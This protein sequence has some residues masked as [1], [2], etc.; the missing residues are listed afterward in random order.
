MVDFDKFLSYN[1]YVVFG[2]TKEDIM[3]LREIIAPTMKDLIKKEII[4]Q[5]LKGECSIGEK[6]PTEREM[7]RS[8]KVSRTVINSALSELCS[9]GFVKIIP[10]QGVFVDD[11]SRNGN[12]DTLIEVM[13]YH[14]GALD[15]KA[16]E[17]LLQYRITAECD[18]SY[19]AAL[20][21]TEEDIK[22]LEAIKNKLAVETDINKIA[23]LKVDFHQA[24]Y[25]ATGN[26]IYPLIYNS[27]KKLSFSFHRLIYQTYG[28][29]EATLYLDQ[30]IHNIKAGRP[31]STKR[32]MSKLLSIRIKQIR[33]H[34]YKN[35]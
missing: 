1:Q 5:I 26:T 20:N 35:N 7:E 25:C 22:T 30:L 23:S 11:Y 31:D 8:M 18:C 3:E 12:I 10:R 28:I 9:M 32:T 29:D 4:H 27:F 15:K 6:L 34:Y 14:D 13:N 33:D 17:S 16:F 21:R 24:I 2:Q 19:L